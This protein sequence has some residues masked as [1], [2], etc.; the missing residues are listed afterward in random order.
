[1][2]R[3]PV[4]G[5]SVTIPICGRK[6]KKVKKH[7]SSTWI[8]ALL[9]LALAVVLAPGN[10][11]ADPPRNSMRLADDAGTFIPA[12]D[13]HRDELPPEYSAN[14]PTYTRG[15]TYAE[16]EVII[17][18][19][20]NVSIEQ[21][22]ALMAANGMHF[23]RPIYG[24]RAFV[25]KVP[26]GRAAIVANA[27]RNNPLLE[28]ASVNHVVKAF[29]DDANDPLIGEQEYL[30]TIKARTIPFEARLGGWWSGGGLH[31]VSLVAVIDTGIEI[32][33]GD[34]TRHPDC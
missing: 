11:F 31:Q 25:A 23:G 28:M 20:P 13:Y 24:D 10:S 34:A 19:G 6:D 26:V 33:G 1:R 8:T 12:A 27:L 18:F 15:D 29:H 9:V 17:R 32:G 16:D 22:N 30:K 4:F 7:R 2:Q 21:Q 5:R 3:I 14:P